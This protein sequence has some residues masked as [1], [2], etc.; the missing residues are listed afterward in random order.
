VT[1][2]VVPS[3]QT[4]SRFYLFNLK[5]GKRRL[6]YG[7]TVDE[8]I[9]IMGYRLTQEEMAQMTGEPP[10]ELKQSEIQAHVKELG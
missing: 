5:S 9:E 4:P 10:Q 3:H 8:A 2:A 6:A 7:R 1:D